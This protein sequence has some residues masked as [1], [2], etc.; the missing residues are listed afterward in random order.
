MRA[1]ARH[2]GPDPRVDVEQDQTEIEVLAGGQPDEKSTLASTEMLSMRALKSR[3]GTA[4][5]RTDRVLPAL[6]PAAIRFVEPRFEVDRRQ[7]GQLEDCR[8]RPGAIAFAEL[9]LPAE[10]AARAEVRQDVDHAGGRRPQLQFCSPAR[11]AADRTAPSR[12]CAACRR[13]RPRPPALSDLIFASSSREPLL[14]VAE[15][16]LRLLVLDPRDRV[17]LVTSSLRALDVVLRL[18]QRGRVL[19]RR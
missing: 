19:F 16:Q 13:H 8:A 10:H 18:H 5:I 12:A 1:T 15:R 9:L 3:P 7:V 14:G 17:P 2:A 4:S 6:Q 11:P